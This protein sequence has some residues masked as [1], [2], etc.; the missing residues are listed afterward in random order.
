MNRKTI[1][2]A[3]CSA[4]AML[5]LLPAMAKPLLGQERGSV[6]KGAREYGNLCGSCHNARSPLERTDRQ[7]VTIM[8]HMRVRANLTGD[9]VRDVL[10]F[11]QAT[12]TDPRE[13]APL[14]GAGAGAPTAGEPGELSSFTPSTDVAVIAE[15][16]RLLSQ[17]ACLGCHVI[18]SQGG[19]LGPSLNGVVQRKGVEFVWQKVADPTINNATSLMPNF[20]LSE[21]EIAAI[22]AFLN[23]LD[24]GDE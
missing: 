1:P 14:E 17:K 8:N 21:E 4:V 18:G 20:G 9:Q 23:T 11:L 15:G 5:M 7:W 6:A 10:A 12:N 19:Q 22:I 13:R 24:G 3:G 2:L 16:E